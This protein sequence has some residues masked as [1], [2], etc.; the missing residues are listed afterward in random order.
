M[1]PPSEI[2]RLAHRLRLG[3]KTIELDYVLTWVLLAIANSPLRERLAFK[4]GTALKKIYEPDYR[5]SED[6]D[7]TLLDDTPNEDLQASI[8]SLFPWLRRE[9][10][11]VLDVRRVEVHQTG[12]PAIYM[13]Y[14]GPLRGSL[15]SRFFKTDFTR[16]ELLLFPPAEASLQTPYSDCQIRAETLL[17]Y[18]PEEILAEKLCALL[19]RTEPRDLF[20]VHYML[21]NQLADLEAVS[22]R[23]SAKMAHKGLDLAALEDVLLRKQDTFGRLWEPRLRGQMPELSHLDT[24]IR[25]TNRWLRQSGLM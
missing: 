5:F 12:N 23:L 10:N 4:G 22:F 8:E 11:L 1:I 14:V 2:A 15:G 13:N 9:V 24:V 20:D 3:D 7:F 16:D 19:G 6:L 25:E 17:V 21:T 18:S